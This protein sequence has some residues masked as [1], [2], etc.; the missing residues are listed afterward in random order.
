MNLDLTRKLAVLQA[1]AANLRIASNTFHD[2]TDLIAH[3]EFQNELAE[4]L[5]LHRADGDV[6]DDPAGFVNREVERLE[7]V[8]Q[9]IGDFVKEQLELGLP[10]LDPKKNP[11][12]RQQIVEGQAAAELALRNLVEHQRGLSEQGSRDG[13]R[14]N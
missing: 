8:L 11:L 2:T 14:D 7:R 9:A 5:A 6:P 3:R 1:T 12:A 13:Q 10:L 4:Y